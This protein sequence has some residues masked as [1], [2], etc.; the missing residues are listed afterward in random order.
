MTS[1]SE[2][3]ETLARDIRE[4]GGTHKRKATALSLLEQEI[5]LISEHLDRVRDVHKEQLRRIVRA[6]TYVDTDLITLQSYQPGVFLFRLKARDNL[7]G[8]LLKLDMERRKLI[9]SHEQ[10]MMRLQEKLFS[11]MSQHAHLKPYNGNS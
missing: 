7:E 4:R 1:I 9:A 2:G 11:L 5:G 10:E 6:E 8:K 3:L